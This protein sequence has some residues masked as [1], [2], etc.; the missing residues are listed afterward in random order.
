ME[1]SPGGENPK[2]PIPDRP[3]IDEAIEISSQKRR[4]ERGT[5]IAKTL[6]ET[7][8]SAEKWEDNALLRAVRRV[9]KRLFGS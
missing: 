1:G 3:L 6:E 7:E 8:D 4:D 9:R 2:L 5:P